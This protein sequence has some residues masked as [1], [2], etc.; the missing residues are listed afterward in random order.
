MKA[1][2][3]SYNRIRINKSIPTDECRDEA[4]GSFGVGAVVRKLVFLAPCNLHE[5]CLDKA[6]A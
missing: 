4:D 1:E 5:A 2:G 3:S 6:E